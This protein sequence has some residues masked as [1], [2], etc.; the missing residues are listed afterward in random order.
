[1]NVR[2][3]RHP[4]LARLQAE[5]EELQTDNQYRTAA[6]IPGVNLSSN[7]YLGLSNDARLKSAL[8]AAID[9]TGRVSSTGS[10]LLSGHLSVW[11]DLETQLASFVGTEASL[12]FS[13]GYTA[14]IAVLTSILKPNTIVFSDS[15]NHASIIDGIRLSRAAKV[16]FTHSD[17]DALERVLRSSSTNAERFIVVESIFSMDGDRARLADIYKLADRYDA[18]LIIDEAHATG[19]VGPAGRGLVAS[20]GRPDCVLATV[21]TCGKALASMGAFVA[22]SDMMRQYLINKARPFIFSTALPPYI[23][24]QTR[25]A[26][27]IAVEA[28]EERNRLQRMSDYLRTELRARGFDIGLSD[29]QI[30]P[31]I[32][33]A[34]EVALR[35]A[36]HLRRLGFGVKAI[37]PPTVPRGTARLRLSLTAALE[38]ADVSSL[39]QTLDDFC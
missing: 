8:V 18:A 21:H 17:L 24:A 23:A 37:R 36:E 32:L 29:S 26:V 13:S 31:L 9:E 30:V 39:I 11:D 5:L 20:A 14:N 1:M 34:N 27:T 12:Y 16:I 19:V 4:A 25:A 2:W 3:T 6:N 28:Q 35:A 22:C 10:R 15:A 33:G 38:M 7:D